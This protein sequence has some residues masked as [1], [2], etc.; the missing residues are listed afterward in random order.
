MNDCEH[1]S[2]KGE[3]PVGY[4]VLCTECYKEYLEQHDEIERQ[5]DLYEHMH[6]LK[7]SKRD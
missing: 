6:S 7:G 1:C 4:V 5:I 2:K 3:H